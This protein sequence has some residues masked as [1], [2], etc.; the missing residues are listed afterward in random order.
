MLGCVLS[1]PSASAAT[2]RFDYDPLGRLVPHVDSDGQVTEYVDNA[3]GNVLEVHRAGT[4]DQLVATIQSVAP[5]SARRGQAIAVHAI[6]TNFT[7]AR[8]RHSYDRRIELSSSTDFTT[9]TAVRPDGRQ[10]RFN[11]SGGAWV[12]DADIVDRLVRLTDGGGN[13]TGWSYTTVNEE[14]E[15]YDVNGR[16]VST[17]NRAG[18]KQTLSSD[19]NARLAS[20]TDPFGRQLLFAY[21]ALDR[22][23]TMT[24]PNGIHTYAYVAS[25]VS[26]DVLGN[27]DSVTYPDTKVRRYHYNESAYTGGANLPSA[28]TGITDENDSRFAIFKYDTSNCRDAG[29]RA[30]W[31]PARVGRGELFTDA[32]EDHAAG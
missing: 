28:P 16:L 26:G 2:Q 31:C 27:L 24:A 14:T 7:G 21:D 6:G 18:L 9:A 25:N 4:A 5:A 13:P 23:A 10:L 20:V 19:G 8:W 32:G 15:E 17:T 12:P 3:V 30:G 29:C 22:I 1:L 11:L